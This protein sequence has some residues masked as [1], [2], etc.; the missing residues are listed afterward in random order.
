M[1][2][3]LRPAKGACGMRDT[4][5]KM[6]DNPAQCGTLGHPT[7]RP[8]DGYVDRETTKPRFPVASSTPLNLF[9]VYF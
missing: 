3:I 2:D 4:L 8:E 5:L 7:Q 9:K 1:R 6:R